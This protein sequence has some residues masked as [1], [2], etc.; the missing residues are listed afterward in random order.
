M[1]C[2]IDQYNHLCQ[3]YIAVNNNNEPTDRHEGNILLYPRPC[4][5]TC[6]NMKRIYTYPLSLIDFNIL[7]LKIN[8]SFITNLLEFLERIVKR[9]KAERRKV[10]SSM[11]FPFPPQKKIVI[12]AKH[13]IGDTISNPFIIE[14]SIKE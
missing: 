10:L 2:F 13:I 9:E 6:S 5:V 4:F 12:W 1:S 11:P 8:P 3:M 14:S 7:S